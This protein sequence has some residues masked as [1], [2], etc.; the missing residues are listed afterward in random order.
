MPFPN[1]ESSALLK[2]IW[3]DSA[4]SHS[5]PYY[6]SSFHLNAMCWPS[7]LLLP[8]L[9][10]S[11]SPW[12]FYSLSHF[13][14]SHSLLFSSLV[15]MFP[16]LIADL[17]SLSH[18]A[19]LPSYP[20]FLHPPFCHTSY[21]IPLL[22]LSFRASLSL[23][24]TSLPSLFILCFLLSFPFLAMVQKQKKKWKSNYYNWCTCTRACLHLHTRNVYS[25]CTQT[26][27]YLDSF[28]YSFSCQKQQYFFST[29]ALHILH[30]L[31]LDKLRPNTCMNL[32][33][34]LKRQQI[35]ANYWNRS[36][37]M[38]VFPNWQ[39]TLKYFHITLRTRQLFWHLRILHRLKSPSTVQ[40]WDRDS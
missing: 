22:L 34:A 4:T 32:N 7:S 29:H 25:V 1:L 37:N 40:I 31:S 30:R 9:L 15:T 13:L 36:R 38:H 6:G 12:P 2:Q 5:F 23:T 11:S 33:G 35:V 16:L 18:L 39:I 8:S 24:M 26:N 3:N 20:S 10:L 19:L 21:F 17:L 27:F 28:I 14:H